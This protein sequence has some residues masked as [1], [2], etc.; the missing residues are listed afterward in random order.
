M[1]SYDFFIYEFI[2]FMNSYMNLGVPRFQMQ[3]SP[4]VNDSCYTVATVLEIYVATG[5]PVWA[6]Q[7][8]IV[9]VQATC[10]AK[11]GF[12]S[13]GGLLSIVM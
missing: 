7:L 5:P 8:A 3:D 13:I 1:N 9:L 11:A 6:L 10:R 2:C 4:A 12:G